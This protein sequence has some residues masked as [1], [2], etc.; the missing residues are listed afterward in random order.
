MPQRN[1]AWLAL[2]VGGMA[3]LF[4][5]LPATADAAVRKVVV[6]QG[7]FHIRGYQVRYTDRA[8]RTVRPPRMDGYIVKMYARVVDSRGRHIPVR[9]TM[10]HHVLYK[11][12]GRFPGD[13]RDGVC[14]AKGESFYGTGEENQP[15]R[16][17]KGY[18]YPIHRG[19]R[20]RISWML[21][22][23]RPTAAKAY[24]EYTA[25]IETKR[26]LRAVKPYWL[27][28]TGCAGASDPIFNI[29][30]GGAPGS[31]DRRTRE[32]R[33]RRAG[34][35][36]AANGHIHGGSKGLFLTQPRCGDRLLMRSRPLYGL[37]SHPYYHVLPVLHEPGPIAS[38]WPRTAR[39]IPIAR[40][41]PLR[42]NSV[43]DAQNQHT[44]VMGIMHLYVWHGRGPGAT[45]CAPLPSDLSNPLPRGPGRLGPPH[46]VVPLTGIDSHGRPY[47]ILDP[48]G[49]VTV[50]RGD[51]RLRIGRN[52]FGRRNLSIPLG[53]SVKWTDYDRRRRW[54]NATLANGPEGGGFGSPM[55]FKGDSYTQRF[56]RAGTYR[57]FCTLHPVTMTQIVQVRAR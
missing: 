43:Y 6:R 45:R 26:K 52:S 4:A 27:R 49:P 10:L 38:G 18:G 11:N 20:W 39:G 21:M 5:G 7:P 28:V 17:P 2:L 51:V 29:P 32:F 54:H 36:V 55:L 46:F 12:M 13:R 15:L 30:G 35:I 42:L 48:V 31:T 8:T 44:R 56:T 57:I 41:E 47:T 16:L 40:R 23:H 34:L 14:R 24:I 3:P 19:D 50:S 9:R 22:N 1:A 25:W 33:L 37:P 53:S